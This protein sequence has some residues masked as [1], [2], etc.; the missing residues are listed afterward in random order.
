MEGFWV[1]HI[2]LFLLPIRAARSATTPLEK[3]TAYP[4]ECINSDYTAIWATNVCLNATEVK[5]NR[6]LT[7]LPNLM[8]EI[9]PGNTE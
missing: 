4:E 6:K 2:E 1:E 3:A 9:P 7:F 8:V 5:T